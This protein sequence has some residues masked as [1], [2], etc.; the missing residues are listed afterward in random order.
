[1]AGSTNRFTGNGHLYRLPQ[2]SR[3]GITS[4]FPTHHG[5]KFYFVRLPP[6]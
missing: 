6:I 2:R 1:M 5:R 4:T 3:L